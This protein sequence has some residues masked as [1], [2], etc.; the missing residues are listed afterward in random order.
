MAGTTQPRHPD[1]IAAT[2]IAARSMLQGFS[3]PTAVKAHEQN[4]PR[5]YSIYFT[6][7]LFCPRSKEI[8]YVLSTWGKSPLLTIS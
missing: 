2:M 6:T 3:L 4:C 5:T 7:G 1:T 8:G